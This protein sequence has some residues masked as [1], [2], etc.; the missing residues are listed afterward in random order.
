MH[1]HKF[2]LAETQ[3]HPDIDVWCVA[4]FVCECGIARQILIKNKNVQ[5]GEDKKLREKN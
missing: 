5:S 3:R 1:K 2:Q 4:T